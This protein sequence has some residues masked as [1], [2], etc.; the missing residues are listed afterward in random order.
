[1][2]HHGSPEFE[3]YA[4]NLR[5]LISADVVDSHVQASRPSRFRASLVQSP[6]EDDAGNLAQAFEYHRHRTDWPGGE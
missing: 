6:L 3:S 5:R 1:M 2:A 4:R